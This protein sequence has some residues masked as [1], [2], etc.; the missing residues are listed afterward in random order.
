[1]APDSAPPV[2]ASIRGPFPRPSAQAESDRSAANA[3]PRSS[4]NEA[5]SPES[6]LAEARDGAL[7]LARC[8]GLSEPDAEDVT[9]QAL[10]ECLVAVRGGSYLA[11]RGLVEPWFRG[12]VRHRVVDHWRRVIRLRSRMSSQDVSQV[13]DPRFESA[14]SDVSGSLGEQMVL[15]LALDELDRASLTA[16]R[17]AAAIRAAIAGRGIRATARRLGTT[18]AILSLAKHRAL[19]R[20][21]IIV[22][23]VTRASRI[24]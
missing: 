14:A 8:L 23:Q 9:H 5:R 2:H 7:R 13:T 24:A 18:P 3:Q 4:A 20:L 19:A 16:R 17:G 6:Q 21:E 22:H 15:S 10:L 12:V 11:E 1:M